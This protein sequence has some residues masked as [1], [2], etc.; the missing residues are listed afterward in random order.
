MKEQIIN[1]DIYRR[2]VVILQGSETELEDWLCGQDLKHLVSA[3]TDTDWETTKAISF[4]DDIDIY[5]CAVKPMELPVLCHELSHATLRVLK[6]VGIDPIKAEEAYAYL[7][8][9]LISQVTC[10]HDESLSQ[11]CE[12]ESQH[13]AL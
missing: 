3:I 12:G 7:F 13:S 9:Y 4:D 1:L 11:S 10:L 2:S 6:I 8:E 5:V